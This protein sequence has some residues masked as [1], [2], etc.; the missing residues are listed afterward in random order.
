VSTSAT[1][2]VEHADGRVELIDTSRV[3]ASPLYN[4]D[5]APVPVSRRAAASTGRRK[6]VAALV[7]RIRK[8]PLIVSLHGSDVFIAEHNR[9]LAALARRIGHCI[10]LQAADGGDLRACSQ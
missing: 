3:E 9:L 8:L 7:A 5:L 6:Y 4:H 10:L 2:Q 1:N